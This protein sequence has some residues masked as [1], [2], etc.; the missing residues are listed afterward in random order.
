MSASFHVTVIYYFYC[1]LKYITLTFAVVTWPRENVSSTLWPLN[2]FAPGRGSR[3]LHPPT[4]LKHV[5]S[6]PDTS[7]LCSCYSFKSQYVCFVFLF[8]L[9]GLVKKNES[10]FAR[11]SMSLSSSI[12]LCHVEQKACD[13]RQTWK[14]PLMAS[15][16]TFSNGDKRSWFDFLNILWHHCYC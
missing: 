4:C 3:Q 10:F 1:S 12:C 6:H 16:H 14:S 7:D 9:R 13:S 15:N 2:R 8:H 11:S 5:C